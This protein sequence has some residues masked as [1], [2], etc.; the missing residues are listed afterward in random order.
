M[1]KK[2]NILLISN[3]M[4]WCVCLI[5][6]ILIFSNSIADIIVVCASLFFIFI[7]LKNND[8]FWLRESWVKIC[9][10]IYFWLIVTSFFAYNEELALSRSVSWIRFIIFSASLQFFFLKKQKNINKLIFCTLIALIYVNIEMFIEKFTGYSLYNDLRVAL[11]ESPKFAGGPDRLSGPFKDAPK[12]GIYL[13]YFIFP[14]ILGVLQILKNRFSYIPIII[15]SFFILNVYLIYESGHR[16]SMISIFISIMAFIVY[17]FWKKKKIIFIGFSIFCISL[18]SYYLN[19]DIKKKENVFNKTITEVKNYNNSAYGALSLTALKMFKQNPIFGIGLKNYRVAC[20]KD[21]FLSEGH[22]G[23][24]YGVSPWK[25]HYNQGL[26]KYY[27]GTCSSHPHNLYLTL[28]AETGL[29][30]FLFFISFIIVLCKK[31]IENKKIVS[32]QIIVLGIIITLIPKLIPMMPALNFFSNWNA[33]CFWFLIG[34]LLS[35]YSKEN[36]KKKL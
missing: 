31:I 35:F 32:N 34:W 30:G 7:S 36:L 15:S 23:T 20:E 13:A 1:H 33:I 2:N 17:F 5:P 28:L 12:S 3:F 21:E 6:L 11:F 24:G 8:W 14:V 4:S 19:S 26:Q 10:L 18:F 29:L 9:L 16:A 25:G 22:K 27:E